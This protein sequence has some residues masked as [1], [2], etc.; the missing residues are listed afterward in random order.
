MTFRA[1]QSEAE[2]QVALKE[3]AAL[4]E[5]NPEPGT[6]KGDRLDVLV[7]KV[8]IYEAV[9]MPMEAPGSVNAIKPQA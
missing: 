1:L 5:K 8:Q 4:M 3:A 7:T 2:H 6:P 9:H